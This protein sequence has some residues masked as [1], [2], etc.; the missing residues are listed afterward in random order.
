MQRFYAYL[1]FGSRSL[2]KIFNNPTNVLFF[3]KN[4]IIYVIK[5][6]YLYI[7]PLVWDKPFLLPPDQHTHHRH[8][9][10]EDLYSF[11]S[12]SWFL[13]DNI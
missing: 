6:S 1:H 5:N 2:R 9:L 11:S 7:H 13:A 3:S 8:L 10:E 12:F 4:L